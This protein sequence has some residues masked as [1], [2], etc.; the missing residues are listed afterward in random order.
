MGKLIYS[1]ITSLDGYAEDA[2]GKFG[3]TA[4]EDEEVHE[5]VNHAYDS[6]GTYLY[7][8]RMYET[9]VYWETADQVPDQPQV[10]LDFAKSWQATDKIVYSM[11]LEQATSRRTKIERTFDPEA[12]RSLKAESD[13]DLTVDGPTLAASAIKA[14]LVDEIHQLMCPVIVGGGNPFFPEDA[15]V[16]LDLLDEQRFDNGVVFLRYRTKE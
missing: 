5:F 13:H 4:V 8:R 3:W 1:M 7:G 6:V 11:T 16:R 10:L 15:R 14:G 12:V 2:D 9:M